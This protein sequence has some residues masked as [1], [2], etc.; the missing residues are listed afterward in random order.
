MLLSLAGEMEEAERELRIREAAA[1]LRAE[2]EK[3]KAAR[4]YE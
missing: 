2:E 4:E 3:V 1:G